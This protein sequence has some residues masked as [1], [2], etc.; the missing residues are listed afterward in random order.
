MNT[1]FIDFKATEITPEKQSCYFVKPKYIS[2][3][4]SQKASLVFGE[5]GSGKTTILRYLEK[6]FNNSE[7]FEYIGAYYRFETAYV[8]ALNN[9]DLSLEQNISAFSQSMAAI[10]GKLLCGVLEDIKKRNQIVYEREQLICKK[11]VADIE[12]SVEEN[13]TTY[14]Q[15]ANILERIRKKTLINLQN[16]KFVCYF[17]Y[18]SFVTEL[19]EELRN[20]TL[21]S[22]TCFCVLLD[23]YENLTFT[24]QRVVNSFIKASSY[25]LTYKVCMRPEGFLTKDTVADKEQLIVGHDYEEFDYV[26]DIVGGE[27]EVKEHLRE[28]CANRLDYFYT[29]QKVQCNREEL[30]IDSYLDL[31]KDEVDIESWG[32]IEE[33]KNELKNKLKKKYPKYSN[34]ID[35][36]ENV[37]DLKLLNVLS[38]KGVGRDEIFKNVSSVTEKYKNWIHNY[39][40][41]IIFQIISECEQTKKYCG[42]DTFIKL[43][44]SNTRTILEILHYAFG[45]YNKFGKVYNRISVKRQTDA[46]NRISDSSFEQIDYIP[47]NGYKAKNLANAL[48]NIFEACLRDSR[49]KKFEVNSFSIKA[50]KQLTQEKTQ[51]LKSVLHD[52]VVWGVL[53]PTKATKIKNKGDIIFD[54]RDYVLHPVFAPHFKISYRKRQKCEFKDV[55][56]YSMLNPKPRKEINAISKKLNQEY[57]QQELEFTQNEF[58]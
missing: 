15:L 23:E 25:F 17:D 45:D 51:E 43:S 40:Q 16:G 34:Y 46:V 53:I 57:V 30:E 42:F 2:R 37:I 58:V 5:R 24:E 48:G 29:Q 20:E 10:I 26:R 14:A 8:K 3:L 39:K 54:G 27:K 38:E 49:A 36:V 33:Y 12:L 28:I 9:P 44:N 19:C 22:Q 6:T 50:T 52:A 7:T 31:I 35:T 55:E 47:V 13:I 4:V 56:V 32:R 21:F 41:N 18:T 11:I 1:P